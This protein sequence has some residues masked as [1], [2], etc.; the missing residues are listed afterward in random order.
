MHRTAHDG[1]HMAEH[2]LAAEETEYIR[3]Q[4][5]RGEALQ[6]CID[7]GIGGVGADTPLDVLRREL[8]IHYEIPSVHAL[9]PAGV[10]PQTA[11]APVPS[12]AP[13]V[14]PMIPADPVPS[15]APPVPPVG[16]RLEPEPEPETGLPVPVPG[17]AAAP[18]GRRVVLRQG[19]L[20][21]KG[22]WTLEIC[23]GMSGM[24]F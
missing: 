21:K 15:L 19:W 3:S 8:C 7:V 17:P 12:L 4:I 10:V 23:S 16:R 11:A 24:S 20:E 2:Y 18:T 22:P 9:A 5:P 13:P 14:P 6:A 1:R